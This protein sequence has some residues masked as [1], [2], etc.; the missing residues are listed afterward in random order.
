MNGCRPRSVSEDVS[1]PAAILSLF[2][3]FMFAGVTSGHAQSAA[4]AQPSPQAQAQAA[5]NDD[6]LAEAARKVRAKKAKSAPRKV[7]TDDDVS[8]SGSGVSVVG[9]AASGKSDEQRGRAGAQAAGNS[10]KLDEEYWRSRARELHYEIDARDQ[11]I[12]RIKEDIKKNGSS[13]FDASS[14]L[15]Q[16]V[17]YVDDKNARIQKLEKEKAE[18]QK[19][20]DELQEEGRKAGAP[21]GWFR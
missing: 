16:N 1:V 14:G 17:I 10:G 20:L 15:Q 18:F 5:P 6:N 13:G 19:K 9:Q 11:K 3:M 21:A 4:P 12:A 2:L 7:Y 8:R